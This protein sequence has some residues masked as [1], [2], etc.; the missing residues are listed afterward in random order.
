MV[1]ILLF[2]ISIQGKMCL[3]QYPSNMRS[4]SF[5]VGQVPAL[6][7]LSGWI[8]GFLKIPYWLFHQASNKF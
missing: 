3:G 6:N 4:I 8:P 7:W 2:K 1:N 5:L